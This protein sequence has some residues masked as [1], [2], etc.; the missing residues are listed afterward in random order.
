MIKK[1]IKAILPWSPIVYHK[2]QRVMR[3][4]KNKFDAPTIVLLYHRVADLETDP[5]LLAVSLKNFEEQMQYL[6]E[7]YPIL[8]FEDDWGKVEKPSVVITFDDGYLDNYLNAKPILEKYQIPATIFVASGNI[9]SDK[10]F[11]WDDLERIIL[12]NNHLPEQY[13]VETSQG[14]LLMNFRGSKSIFESYMKLHPLL[15][16]VQV[17]EREAVIQELE[18]NLKPN[19][20]YRAL[21]RT[22]NETELREMDQSP[23]ITLGGHTVS[24]TALAIQSAEVQEEEIFSSKARLESIMGHEITTFSYPFGGKNDYTKETVRI[25]R[26]AGYKKVASNFPGQIHSSD[27]NFYEYPRQLV[28]NWDIETFKDKLNVFWT[29]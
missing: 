25:V 12:L 24:H 8:R 14:S 19:L 2:S 18:N 9:G 15:K 6:K 11:W 10:E 23:Y 22:M 5:Q 1:I 27:T 17:E 28:R 16:S 4:I 20:S 3:G 29:N 13:K 7:N 26:E 21:Y